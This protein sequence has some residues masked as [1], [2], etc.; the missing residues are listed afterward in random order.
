MSLK[1]EKHKIIDVP[2]YVS[3]YKVGDPKESL[4]QM[5]HKTEKIAKRLDKLGKG[6]PGGKLKT[7]S[8]P[9]GK[10]SRKASH[11]DTVLAVIRRSKKRKGAFVH[12]KPISTVG[13][14][15][16]KRL[17]QC[18]LKHIFG[19]PGDY[20]LE[21]FD[22]LEESSIEL[23]GTCNEL[24]AGYA[25]DGYSRAASLGAACITYGVG[26]LS[27]ANAVGGAMAERIPMVVISGSPPMAK[28]TPKFRL[29]HTLEDHDAIRLAFEPITLAAISLDNPQDAPG[30]IDDALQTSLNERGPVYFELPA[31]MVSQSCDEPKKAVLYQDQPAD[32]AALSEAVS[33]AAEMVAKEDGPI[34]WAGHEIRDF[35][36]INRLIRFVEHTGFPVLSTRQSKGIFPE[37][38][39]YYGGIYQGSSSRHESKNLFESAGAVLALGVWW[40]DI[41]TGGY[42]VICDPEK[43][44][45]AERNFIKIGKQVFKPV[46]LKAF[47][48]ALE[49]TL[50]A[51][52]L[53]HPNFVRYNSKRAAR[54]RHKTGDK[55]TANRFFD[56]LSY[57]LKS[58]HFVLADVG[59]AMIGSSQTLLPPGTSYIV[60]GFYLSIGYTLPAGLGVGLAAPDKRPIILI[61]DGAIQMTGQEISTMIRQGL[62]PII[63][64]INN[65]GYQVERAI[66]DGPYNDIQPWNFHLLPKIFGAGWGL[67]VETEGDLEKALAKAEHEPD[68]LALIEVVLDRWDL[69]DVMKDM[70]M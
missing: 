23:I 4:K 27:I 69:P 41:N 11:G 66:H 7:K 70:F 18:G 32:D 15:L 64:I 3:R 12:N 48:E 58:D 68:S 1:G 39:P 60:Q 65:D 29:H 67:R 50:P 53:T 6:K 63:F 17:E 28:R 52:D 51:G 26:G 54:F 44:V 33:G 46:G 5:T 35:G 22:L 55:L 9:K 61:G 31:D 34:V 30:L 56:R 47:I 49:N 20:V 57:F 43:V 38:H 62:N 14:Y 37:T 59:Q 19:V 42:S 13:T 21:F 25:A 10:A 24:N 40:T 45:Q 2:L 8:A 36:A 16:I